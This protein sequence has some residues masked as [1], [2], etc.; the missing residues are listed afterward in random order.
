MVRKLP[1][2]RGRLGST[3]PLSPSHQAVADVTGDDD[4]S[5]VFTSN[6]IVYTESV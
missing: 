2:R 4:E 3:E 5:G 1:T 6:V